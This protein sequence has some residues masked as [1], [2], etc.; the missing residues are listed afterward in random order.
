MLTKAKLPLLIAS[1]LLL[2]LIIYI[3]A[4]LT[5]EE[6]NMVFAE[7]AR[8]S[9]RTSAAINLVLLFM[10]GHFG[11]KAIFNEEIKKNVFRVL[12]TLFAVNHVVHFFFVS[13]NFKSQLLDLDI[14]TNLHGVIT[15]FFIL[16]LPVVVWTYKKLN[17]VLYFGILLHLFNVTYIIGDTFYGRYKPSIDAA[18]LHRMGVVIMIGALL[19]ALYRVFREWSVSFVTDDMAN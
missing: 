12:L 5:I 7:C 14:A 19:Y 4:V 11:L 17:P 3:R 1:I 9:G 15:Y 2:N 18:Y 13:Q 16:A 8:N 10:L 6:A